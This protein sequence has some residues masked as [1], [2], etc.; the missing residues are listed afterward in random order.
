M[1]SNRKTLKKKPDF[2]K[3][4]VYSENIYNKSQFHII[5]N[6]CQAIKNSQMVYDPKATGRGMYVIDN[7]DPI[8]PLIY[9]KQFIN[10]VRTL[11]GNKKLKPCLTVPVEYR[12][13]VVGSH[14]DWHKDTQMV[15][16][17]LQ[18][19]CV[20]T[21]KNNSDSHTLF[22]YNDGIRKISS[23]PNSLLIV[24]ANGVNHKVTP[25][26]NGERTILKL[27]FCE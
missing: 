12:K 10:K 19:E 9:N 4:A 6:Y 15:S 23:T 1:G 17:Q 2:N 13:Y 8:I 25:L 20:I 3:T 26:E 18:Y 22:M 11:T 16:G 5:Q 21:V 14:M 24:R 7:A 27:V